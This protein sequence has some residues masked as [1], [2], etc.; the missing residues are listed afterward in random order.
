MQFLHSLKKQQKLQ[1]LLVFFLRNLPTKIA[2]GIPISFY[3][4]RFKKRLATSIR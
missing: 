2:N 4:H 1:Y 3:N